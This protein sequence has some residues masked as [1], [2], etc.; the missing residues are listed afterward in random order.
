MQTDYTLK[1][2]AGVDVPIP[3]LQITIHSPTIKEIGLV[4]EQE[5]FLASQY[6]C[7]QKESLIQDKTLLSSLSNFQVLMKVLEQSSDRKEK[8]GAIVNLLSLLFP[9][10][11]PAITKNSIILSSQ[12]EGQSP[13][14]IDNNNFDVLQDAIKKIL[15]LNNIFQGSNII[16]NPANDRAREIAEKLNK[17]RQ[18]IQAMK[19]AQG[20]A[21]ESILARYVSI[22]SVAQV[23]PLNEG[24]NYNLFQLF[25]LM[26]RYNS[27]IEW[28]TDLQVRLAGGKPDSSPESWMR[29]LHC[30]NQAQIP[31]GAGSSQIKVYK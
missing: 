23:A 2:M 8:K 20:Q 9:S 5:F 26:E 29:D 24:L 13:I 12:E 25:D 22:L 7:L 14:L 18:K 11:V 6:L 19:A 1:L 30:T 15:C 3:E 16:Y 4:G 21:S 17:S 27:Y 10:Y 31:A 28:N